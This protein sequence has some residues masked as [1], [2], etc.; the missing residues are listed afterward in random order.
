MGLF[1]W[2][3]KYS[4]NVKRFDGDHKK[5]FSLMNELNEAMAKGRGRFIVQ[6][7]LLQ[8]LDYTKQHF[9]V[10]EAA[11]RSAGVE[12]LTEHIALHRDLTAKV[13]KYADD[14]SNGNTSITI[15][16]LY[17]LND[18]LTKHILTVDFTYREAMSKANIS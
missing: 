6:D 14:Y 11:M 3:D 15:D 4:V 12:N 5:L 13:Q 9:A 2:K 7:V 8:L 10:E 18:W 1:E 16:V 17:F